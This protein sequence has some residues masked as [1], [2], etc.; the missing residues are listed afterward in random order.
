MNKFKALILLSIP[1][2]LTFLTTSTNV[3]TNRIDRSKDITLIKLSQYDDKIFESVVLINVY[4][5]IL[6]KTLPV[7]SGTGFSVKYDKKTN[8][9]YLITNHHICDIAPYM[10]MSFTTTKDAIFADSL[11]QSRVLSIVATDESN[12]ICIVAAK[13]TYIAPVKLGKSETL[14]PME[15][16]YSI[17]APKGVFP[18]WVQGKFSGRILRENFSMDMGAGHN[19]ILISG[20]FVGGQSGSPIYDK[21]GSVIGVLFASYDDKEGTSYGGLAIPVEAITDLMKKTFGG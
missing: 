19:F 15:S 9:S 6:D 14:V 3:E 12:D 11:S 13:D 10:F 21:S 18:I 2:L 16:L 8:T 1:I 17:G 20:I 5:T 7:S 4:A